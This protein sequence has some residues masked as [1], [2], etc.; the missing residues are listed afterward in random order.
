MTREGLVSG[1][2]TSR[3]SLREF[4]SRFSRANVETL[5]RKGR[6]LLSELSFQVS[7]SQRGW[8]TKERINSEHLVAEVE[9]DGFL[10]KGIDGQLGDISLSFLLFSRREGRRYRSLN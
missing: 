8:S 10:E 3:C 1:E 7:G 6:F 2:G 9:D 5:L 4:E